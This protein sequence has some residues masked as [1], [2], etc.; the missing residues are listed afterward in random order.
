MQ[1]NS[2]SLL[3]RLAPQLSLLEKRDWELWAIVAV[4][5]ILVSLGLVALALPTMFTRGEDI[6]FEINVPRPLALGLIV[7]IILMNTYLVSRRLELR[8]VREQL[9]STT[10]QAQLI[11]QQSFIDPLTDVYNRRS[12]DEIVGRFIKHARRLKNPLTFLMVDVNNF[13]Q[14]NTKFGHLTGDTV[15]AEIATLL[16]EAVRGSDAVVRYGGDE[17]L[18]CLADTDAVGSR[19]VIERIN[20]RIAD[21]N[22][23]SVLEHFK[24]GVSIGGAE[25]HDGETLDEVLDVADR[26]MYEH[27]NSFA[28]IQT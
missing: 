4:T 22:S 27:K 26:K 17:F 12:L 28:N 20:K 1:R 24:V 25:W 10:L 15:L 9:I 5:G 6:H 13:K 18:V 21:W 19:V 11:E 16:K 23:A 8:R 7:L 2:E 3:A 14:V